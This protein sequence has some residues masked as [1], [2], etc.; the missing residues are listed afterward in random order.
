MLFFVH[1]VKYILLFP[2]IIYF[3]KSENQ[4][5]M[6]FDL[7]LKKSVVFSFIFISF[8]KQIFLFLFKLI[9]KTQ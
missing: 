9:M 2:S 1:H 8:E 4:T 5:F 7:K 6:D 3:K